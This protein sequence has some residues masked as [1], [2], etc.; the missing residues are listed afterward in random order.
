ML[1]QITTIVG[2]KGS[3]ELVVEAKHF[4]GIKS[5]A[6]SSHRERLYR[7]LQ[8]VSGTLH[9]ERS[10]RLV[11]WLAWLGTTAHFEPTPARRSQELAEQ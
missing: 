2:G 8:E 10:S 5:P 7:G 3:T 4:Q 1:H 9:R 11:H 6:C